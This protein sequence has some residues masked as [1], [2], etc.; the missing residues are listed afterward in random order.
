MGNTKGADADVDTAL[1]LADVADGLADLEVRSMD[2]LCCISSVLP[3]HCALS[4][5]AAL[6]EG[7]VAAITL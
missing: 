1:H 3:N 2:L 4:F 6:A 5:A 7:T